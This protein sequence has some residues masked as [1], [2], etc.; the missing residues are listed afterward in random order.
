M[1]NA[2]ETLAKFSYSLTFCHSKT[3]KRFFPTSPTH[4]KCWN[5]LHD[6]VNMDSFPA[7]ILYPFV[8]KNSFEKATFFSVI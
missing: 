5:A 2:I 1:E 4:Q 6:N 7:G 3:S 8:L